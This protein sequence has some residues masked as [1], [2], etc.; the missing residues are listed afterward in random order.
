M[1]VQTSTETGLSSGEECPPLTIPST[2]DSFT[3]LGYSI[4]SQSGAYLLVRPSQDGRNLENQK[5]PTLEKTPVLVPECRRA[6][7]EIAALFKPWVFQ[8][9]LETD[10]GANK[11]RNQSAYWRG[12]PTFDNPPQR[13]IVYLP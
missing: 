3:T 1:M 6:K 4:I 11:H 13:W 2:M 8:A 9:Y 7:L 5:V 10:D 12:V